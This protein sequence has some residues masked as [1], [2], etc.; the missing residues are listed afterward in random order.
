M[1]ISILTLME[2]PAV[3]ERNIGV[4]GG[5]FFT[6]VEVGGVPG[7]VGIGVIA[8]RTGGFESALLV[9]AAICVLLIGLAL[10]VRWLEQKSGNAQA[11]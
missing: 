3:G 1:T 11:V 7:P 4:A 2:T 10:L 5:L 6:S 8:D 9:L